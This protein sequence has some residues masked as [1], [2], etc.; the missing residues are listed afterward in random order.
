MKS[1]FGMKGD[2]S[3]KAPLYIKTKSSKANNA[4]FRV[5][6]DTYQPLSNALKMLL[7]TPAPCL[8]DSVYHGIA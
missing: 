8:A 3:I 6:A 1:F 7:L 4:W 2:E 5:D